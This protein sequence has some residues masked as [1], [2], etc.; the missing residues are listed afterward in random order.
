M[1][2]RN[3]IQPQN[4]VGDVAFV[5]VQRQRNQAPIRRQIKTERHH[6]QDDERAKNQIGVATGSHRRGSLI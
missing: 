6:A 1:S 4:D 5:G 3:E 2:A